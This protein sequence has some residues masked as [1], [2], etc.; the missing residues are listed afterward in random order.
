MTTREKFK[1]AVI[2]AIHGL[3]YDEAVTEEF[4]ADMINCK[5]K[6]NHIVSVKEDKIIEGVGRYRLYTF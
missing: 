3:P 4:F 1:R 5:I 2:E 6:K